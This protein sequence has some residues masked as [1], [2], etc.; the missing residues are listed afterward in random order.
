LEAEG[1]HGGEVGTALVADEREA[2]EGS[3][4]S[5]QGARAMLFTGGRLRE[6]EIGNAANG[7]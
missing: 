7:A 6:E 2:G 3:T 5:G 4:S 1:L